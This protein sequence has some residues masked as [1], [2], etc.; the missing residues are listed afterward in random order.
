MTI[1]QWK[2]EMRRYKAALRKASAYSAQGKTNLA[3]KHYEAAASIFAR[4]ANVNPR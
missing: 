4:I 2:T 3:A 1:T